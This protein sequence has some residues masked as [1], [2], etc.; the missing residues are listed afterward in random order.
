[1][2]CGKV[3]FV[4]PIRPRRACSLAVSIENFAPRDTPPARAMAILPAGPRALSKP[5]SRSRR[6]SPAA[7][8]PNPGPASTTARSPNPPD[9][10][11]CATAADTNPYPHPEQPAPPPTPAAAP[12]PSR[13]PRQPA[14]PASSECAKKFTAT[15]VTRVVSGRRTAVSARIRRSRLLPR[16]GGPVAV[17]PGRSPVE[18]CTRP[19]PGFG[20]PQRPACRQ[21]SFSPIAMRQTGYGPPGSAA[22]S[23]RR[24]AGRRRLTAMFDTYAA[25]KALR[26]AGFDEP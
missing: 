3:T 24:A 1:M 11:R 13:R 7:A 19:F 12:R 20:R 14:A 8:R 18:F 4:P 23:L 26:N 2:A 5:A 15:S 21:F 16:C 25:A 9:P 10:N 17:I 6:A 22:A